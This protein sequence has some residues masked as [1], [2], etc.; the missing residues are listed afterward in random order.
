MAECPICR[1]KVGA[2][3][4]LPSEDAACSVCGNHP[5]APSASEPW[6]VSAAPP[7]PRRTEA[8]PSDSSSESLRSARVASEPKVRV[9]TPLAPAQ[10]AIISKPSEREIVPNEMHSPQPSP[11]QV[12]P[13]KSPPPSPDIFGDDDEPTSWLERLRRIDLGSALA[14]LCFGMALLFTSFYQLES[15]IKPIAAFG[16]MAGLLG[17]FVPAL[18]RRRNVFLPLVMSSFCLLVLLFAGSWPSFSS[19]PPPLMSVSLSS[20]GMGTHQAV[21]E[22]D[23]VD[24]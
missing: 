17:G 15:F 2:N 8:A 6:W 4:F 7:V 16:L 13:S 10:P 24:A 1:E 11:R 12:A 19:S 21:S 14:F 9:K 18:R 23:W 5:V 22:D 3:D 20:K